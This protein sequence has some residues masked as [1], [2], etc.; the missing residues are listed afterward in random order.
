MFKFIRYG[1]VSAVLT[2]FLVLTALACANEDTADPLIVGN[3]NTFTGSLSEFGP[4]LRN[5]IELASNHVNRA[6]GVNG[7]PML[8][9]SRDTAVNPVQGVD[10]ARS[11]VDVENVAGYRRRPLQRSHRSRGQRGYHTS[12][13]PHDLRCVHR[14]QHHGPRRQRL[15]LPHHTFRR[16]TGRHIG[17]S[18]Q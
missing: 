5:A 8:I 3:L 17:A 2:S 10:A 13:N 15:P 14:P 1:L 16:L 7:S 18:R 4:P 11:L 9:I 12:T 6:G